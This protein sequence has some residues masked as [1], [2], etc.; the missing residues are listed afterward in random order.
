MM[1]K[2]RIKEIISELN[3]IAERRRISN[4][5]L[6]KKIG[7]TMNTVRRWRKGGNYPTSQIIIDRLISLLSEL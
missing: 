7:V 6:G 3:R 4:T 2:D 5:L 1:D